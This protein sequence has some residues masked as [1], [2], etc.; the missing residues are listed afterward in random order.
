MRDNQ[1]STYIRLF[2]NS[3]VGSRHHGNEQIN[4]HNDSEE[5][6][7]CEHQL[8]H[9]HRPRLDKLQAKRYFEGTI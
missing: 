1:V 2:L 7:G 8:E 3:E 6:V 9:V 5:E 4:K